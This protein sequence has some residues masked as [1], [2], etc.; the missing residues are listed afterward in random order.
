MKKELKIKKEDLTKGMILEIFN[1][2]IENLKAL[3]DLV[4]RLINDRKFLEDI[5]KDYKE[6]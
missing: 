6:K 3:R 5:L 4:V 2:E 1:M